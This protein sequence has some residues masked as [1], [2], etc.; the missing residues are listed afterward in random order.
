MS[1]TYGWHTILIKVKLGTL[2]STQRSYFTSP[3]LKARMLL[4]EC[5][6]G[7][8]VP[9]PTNTGH[10]GPWQCGSEPPPP[11]WPPFGELK[12][13]LNHWDA[14]RLVSNFNTE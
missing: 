12:V 8:K 9:D 2:A 3:S 5:R 1:D 7:Q 13:L 10:T 6:I 4:H 14:S 11:T